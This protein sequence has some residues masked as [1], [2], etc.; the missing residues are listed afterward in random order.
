[1]KEITDK[2]TISSVEKLGTAFSIGLLAVIISVAP[3]VMFLQWL[4]FFAWIIL[5]TVVFAIAIRLEKMKQSYDIQTYKEI[6]AFM[7]GQRLDEIQK[8]AERQ[9]S[10]SKRILGVV[11]HFSM[12][13]GSLFSELAVRLILA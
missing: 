3:L 12:F 8:A 7:Q 11:V 6:A 2:N 5:A 13:F 1:M 4:G 9:T 10:L